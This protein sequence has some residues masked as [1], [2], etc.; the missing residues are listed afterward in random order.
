MDNLR[1][2]LLTIICATML[3]AVALRIFEKN[4]AHNSILKLLT[5]IYLS[6]TVISPLTDIRLQ[7]I[8]YSLPDYRVE[9]KQIV[10]QS[11]SDVNSQLRG[12]ITHE[13]EAYILDKATTL[14]IVID[15]EIAL[16]ENGNTPQSVIIKGDI[17]PYAKSRM[18]Q[19]IIKD[20]GIPKERQLWK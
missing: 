16:S 2:Y 11:N 18:Q 12:I 13:A 1:Q 5:G 10:E 6:I 15:A 19:I 8:T 20:L 4:S 9:A 7:D 3:C 17:S 14:G